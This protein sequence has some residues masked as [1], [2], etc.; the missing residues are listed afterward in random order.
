MNLLAPAGL[1]VAIG[2][3]VWQF[4]PTPSPP[5]RPI[6]VE[7]AEARL[8][9]IEFQGMLKRVPVVMSME[10]EAGGRLVRWRFGRPGSDGRRPSSCTVK[11]Q[12]TAPDRSTAD[13]ECAVH[14]PRMQPA[15]A[16]TSAKLLKLVMSEHVDAALEDRDFD[17]ERMGTALMAFAVR[18]RPV[19]IE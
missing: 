17:H 5:D 12:P 7:T 2:A 15:Q 10:E 11:L 13:L 14:N 9:G 4:A 8:Q 19:F 6:P 18:H 1:T 16:E 3:A